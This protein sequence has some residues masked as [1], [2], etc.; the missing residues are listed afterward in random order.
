MEKLSLTQYG[1]CWNAWCGAPLFV[2]LAKYPGDVLCFDCS[3]VVKMW[4]DSASGY[5]CFNLDSDRA[6]ILDAAGD[7]FAYMPMSEVDALAYCLKSGGRLEQFDT[8]KGI[9]G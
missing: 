1:F 9:G 8:W 3:V 5:E 7:V 2:E 6:L 4:K